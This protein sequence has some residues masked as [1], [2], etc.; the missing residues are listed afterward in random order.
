MAASAR[1]MLDHM[2]TTRLAPAERAAL[3]Q[4]LAQLSNS[5]SLVRRAETYLRYYAGGVALV[6]IVFGALAL[7]VAGRLAGDLPPPLSPPDDRAG[8]GA[9][10]DLRR[11][12]LPRGGLAARVR[13]QLPALRPP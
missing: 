5:V 9:R 8:G 10:L 3:R 12:P 4:H 2:D 13:A 7:T 11:L 6:V 1:E